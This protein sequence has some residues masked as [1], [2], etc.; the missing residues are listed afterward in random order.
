MYGSFTMAE[1]GTG[2]RSPPHLRAAL[3][4]AFRPRFLD[5]SETLSLELAE[6]V[7]SVHVK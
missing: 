3:P 5:D 6:H 2:S 4:Q 7:E 1:R